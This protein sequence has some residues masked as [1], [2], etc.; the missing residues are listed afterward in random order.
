MVTYGKCICPATEESY[1]VIVF[2]L[3]VTFLIW[4]FA[5]K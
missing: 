1:T 4:W 2:F 5:R 3:C